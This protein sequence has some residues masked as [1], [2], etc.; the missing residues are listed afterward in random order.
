MRRSRRRGWWTRPRA[1]ASLLSLSL[2]AVLARESPAC[3]CDPRFLFHR[4]DHAYA[5]VPHTTPWCVRI[6]AL[7]VYTRLFVCL[8]ARAHLAYKYV[9][10]C[11]RFLARAQHSLFMYVDLALGF[12][13]SRKV[14]TAVLAGN[15]KRCR[16][17]ANTP[18][19]RLG[20][21]NC[22]LLACAHAETSS[23]R[24]LP[25][26]DTA[27]TARSARGHSAPCG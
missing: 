14:C 5:C 16:L 17:L 8:R 13:Q 6:S 11:S 3:A 4:K 7:S 10:N 26:R 21:T 22:D 2:V 25:W 9:P 1:E 24:H 27:R 15:G 23:E 20:R 19:G 12:I 18:S